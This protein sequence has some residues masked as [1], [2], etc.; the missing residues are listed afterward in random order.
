[1]VG[2]NETYTLVGKR[3]IVFF[4]DKEKVSK[5]E[6]ICTHDSEIELV[7]DKRVILPRTRIVRIEVLQ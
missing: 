7:L 6:G 4:D 1:M 3:I 5:K 2:D